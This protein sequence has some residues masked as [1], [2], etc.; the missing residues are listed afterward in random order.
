LNEE[1]KTTNLI[2]LMVLTY[3][4]KISAL[5]QKLGFVQVMLDYAT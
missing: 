5:P 4:P 2:L 1:G 3:D